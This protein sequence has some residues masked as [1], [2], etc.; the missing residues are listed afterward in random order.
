MDWLFRF[1][2]NRP[3][4]VLYEGL[5]I[6]YET[7][8]YYQ[9][10]VV[11]E[12]HQAMK[13]LKSAGNFFQ[14]Q[15]IGTSFRLPTVMDMLSKLGYGVILKDRFFERLLELGMKHVLRV[16]KHRGEPT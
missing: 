8:K 16:L 11:T 14:I 5:G 7:F 15:G 13:S 3:L 6:P 9:D 10:L 2:L 1:Y 12:A 4:I